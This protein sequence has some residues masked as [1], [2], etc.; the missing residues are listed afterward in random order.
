MLTRLANLGIRA[1]RRILAAAGLL[2]V[3]A[4]LYGVSA[5]SHLSS[6]GFQD[7]KSA[8]STVDDVLQKRFHAGQPNLVVEVTSAAGVDAAATRRAGVEVERAIGASPYADQVTSYWSV[9]AS[10]SKGLVSTDRKSALVVASIAGSDAVAPKRAANLSKPLAGTHDG[11]TVKVGGFGNAFD[12][13]NDQTKKDLAIAEAIAIPLTVIALIWVFGSLLASLLPLVVGLTSIVGTMALLRG[14]ALVTDVSTYSL[15]MTTAMGLALAIDYSLFIVSRYREEIRGG[16]APDAA[17][18]R[19]MQ[20]AGRTV[21]F[22]ALTVG[23]ALAALIVFPQYFLR[24]FAYAGIAVVALATVAALTLLPAMLTLIGPRVDSLD[25]RVFVRRVLGRPPPVVKPVEQTFWYRV[26]NGVMRR[27]LPIGL[28]VTALL[29]GLGLPFL[30]AQFAYPDDRVLPHSASAHQVGD[31][32]RSR[33]AANAQSTV[34]V[35]ATDIRSAPTSIG[36]YAGDLSRL[37]HVTSVTSSA[38]V[39]AQGR[40]VAVAAGPTQRAGNATYLDVNVDVEGHSPAGKAL[41]TKIEAVHPPWKVLY[42]GQ[43]AVNR[44][45][46]SS[47]GS[48]L[49]YALGLIALATFIV[50]FLFTGSVVLPLKALVLNMLSLSATFGAMVWIFQ[51]GHFGSLFNDLTPTGYLVPTM[52]PLMFCLSFGLSMD[53]EVFLLSRIREAW[54]ESDRTPEANTRAVALGLGRTGRIVTAAALL[55][56]IVFAAMAGSKVSFMMLFGTGL[57]LAVL[58]DAT[59]VRGI[60]VPAFMRLAGKW[61]WWAPRP[62]ARLHAKIGLSEEPAAR[63]VPERQPVAVG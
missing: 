40:R 35:L 55:M 58:M 51:Y 60:L 31:D 45:S 22:S 17:V 57:T 14:L 26:A 8:S 62:L 50:L 25:L 48:A 27:A 12:E 34:T 6:G 23:L 1:P 54:L 11:V 4:A 15:N 52:P 13:V 16:S 19:T 37:S 32:V 59:V 20:T 3:L 47:I 53:Y 41:L 9:P 36:S 30:H 5:A 49:P 46:L 21:L 56:A 61:N 63:A 38:G 39:Y 42:G 18:R 2:F 10:Q 43:T 29:V 7:P 44:D 28:V 33:F 24:S